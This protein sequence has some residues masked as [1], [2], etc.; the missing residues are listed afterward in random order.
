MQNSSLAHI[1]MARATKLRRDVD[2]VLGDLLSMLLSQE[3]R[4]CVRAARENLR[5][6]GAE[7]AY[8]SVS[9]ALVRAASDPSAPFPTELVNLATA[10]H[11][12]D[13][14]VPE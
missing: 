7:S 6:L 11:P 1:D 8:R 5:T 12:T 13:P 4:S 14:S 2:R 3:G 9:D 10:L